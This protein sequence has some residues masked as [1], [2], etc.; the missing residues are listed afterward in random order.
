MKRNL[1]ISG[2]SCQHCVRAV[3]EALAE[4][5]GVQLEAIDVGSASIVTESESQVDQARLAIQE[6]GYRV[7]SVTEA[8]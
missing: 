3:K 6:E 4:V 5:P 1:K 2:M 8:G 7:E